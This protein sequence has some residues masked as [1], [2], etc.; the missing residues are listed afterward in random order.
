MKSHPWFS[1]SNPLLSRLRVAAAATLLIAAAAM[2]S[3]ALKS[4]TPPLL[5]KSK[6]PHQTMS[7]ALRLGS[8]ETPANVKAGAAGPQYGLFR[9]QVG[10]I[11]CQCSD[12]YQMRHAYGV[13]SLIAAGFDGT[14]HTIVIVDAFQN[15]NLVTQVI[16]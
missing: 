8:Q 5:R 15:P 13:D 16:T 9:C 10:F 12:P 3:V 7:P 6:R 1:H 11:V 14:G 2:A 4:S